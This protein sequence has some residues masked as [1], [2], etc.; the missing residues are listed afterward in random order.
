M[1]GCH[2]RKVAAQ[3]DCSDIVLSGQAPPVSKILDPPLNMNRVNLGQNCLS[4]SFA[5]FLKFKFK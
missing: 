4:D 2:L 3:G 5:L 1:G